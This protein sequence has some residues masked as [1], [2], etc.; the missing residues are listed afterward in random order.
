MSNLWMKRIV[1]GII[2]LLIGFVVTWAAVTAP[3]ILNTTLSDYGTVYVV[4][5]ILSV[6]CAAGIWLD[7][8]M[9]TDILPK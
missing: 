6:A 4:F 7:K 2:S 5:T 3:F 8:F 1:L 9:G